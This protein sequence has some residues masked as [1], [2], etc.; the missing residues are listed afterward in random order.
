MMA[1]I[2]AAPLTT[3]RLARSVQQRL[4]RDFLLYA[5]ACLAVS[6]CAKEQAQDSEQADSPRDDRPNILLIVA[7]DLGFTDLGVF[8]GEIDTPNLDQLAE[9]GMLLTSFY[10]A[11]NCS[12]TRAMLLSGTDSHIAG[13]GNMFE[14]LAPNQEGRP[15]YEGYLNQRVANLA[16]LL[17]DAGYHTYMTGKWHLGLEEDQSPAARGF[18]K[19]YVLLQGG[20]GH[21]DHLGL[22]TLGKKALYREDG[23]LVELPEDF[24][25]SRFYARRLIEY[26]DTDKEGD[27]PFFGYLAFSAPHW[28]LQA[29]DESIAK[30][31]GRYDAGYDALHAQRLQRAQELGVIPKDVDAFPRLPDERPW[32]SLDDEERK[33]EARN[34]EVFAAMVDD[35]D[36]YV[37]EV[38]DYLK[39]TGRYENTFVFFM[40]DNGAEGHYLHEGWPELEA[41]IPEC[42]DN[43]YENMGQADSYIYY[44]PNWARAGVGPYRMYK[45]FVSE[46]GLHVPAFAHYPKSVATGRIN[47]SFLT[48]MD[49]MPTLLEL[50]GTAHPGSPYKGR[51]VAPL[52]GKSMLSLLS[53]KTKTVHGGDFV[54]GWELFGKRAIRKGDWKLLWLPPPFGTDDWQLYDLAADPAEM[55][56]LSERQPDTR[57]ELIGL[58]Q[59][60]VTDHNIVLPDRVSGY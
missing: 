54:A 19:S 8:G 39:S 48:V 26:I 53:G 5:C 4:L 6:G 1:A 35:L 28:P 11:P 41:W 22:H 20:G 37:G 42:C 24:Y 15:G 51:E 52:S 13:L 3:M 57:E 2:R 36:R 14:E 43:S 33:V 17:Q 16:E 32:E 30:Y 29:P 44:G 56:D 34:M 47:D 18:E 58:W 49:V 60:Y 9:N 12:P 40:S 59:Q 7:D 10:A 31:H 38:I 55:T 21:F 45:G 46:G 25:S 27:R 50:A 23:K